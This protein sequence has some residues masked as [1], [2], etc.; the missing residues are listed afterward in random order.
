MRNLKI[1][2]VVIITLALFSCGGNSSKTEFPIS[3][4][5][6]DAKA[7]INEAYYYTSLMFLKLKGN[8]M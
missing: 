6:E 8:W 7:L 5:S 1:F 2:F 4:E 3:T